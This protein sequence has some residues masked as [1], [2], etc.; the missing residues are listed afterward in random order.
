MSNLIEKTQGDSI[1]GNH[2][3][4]F[5]A[6]AV[7]LQDNAPIGKIAR[8]NYNMSTRRLLDESWPS[9]FRI[10][11]MPSPLTWRTQLP[12]GPKGATTFQI[13]THLMRNKESNFCFW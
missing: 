2:L 4:S 10:L 11:Q 3:A 13:K 12:R 5:I 7:H 1:L 6:A 9:P 8:L